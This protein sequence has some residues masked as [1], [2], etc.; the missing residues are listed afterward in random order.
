MKVLLSFW[1]WGRNSQRTLWSPC[2]YRACIV[3][4]WRRTRKKQT[5]NVRECMKRFLKSSSLWMLLALPAFCRQALESEEGGN[6][7]EK[8]NHWCLLTN[9]THRTGPSGPPAGNTCCD[10]W[11]QSKWEQQ[12]HRLQSSLHPCSTKYTQCALTRWGVRLVG[13]VTKYW[14]SCRADRAMQFYPH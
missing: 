13:S 2:W 4:L 7:R 6:Q 3:E 8:G 12:T 11:T 5:L 10:L 9:I 14:Y 1:F